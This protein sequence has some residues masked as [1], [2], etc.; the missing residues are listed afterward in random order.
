MYCKENVETMF[1]VCILEIYK[2]CLPMSLTSK[3]K[4]QKKS[5]RI[6]KELYII[7]FDC[8]F[9]I[10]N[11][12]NYIR[13]IDCPSCLRFSCVMCYKKYVNRNES[14]NSELQF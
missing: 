2:T 11:I 10:Y 3:N 7:E 9:N 13:I 6:F 14:Y 5:M 4:N 1:E 8:N 12:N